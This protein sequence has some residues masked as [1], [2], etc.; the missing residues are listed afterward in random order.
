MEPLSLQMSTSTSRLNKNVRYRE[1]QK[2]D[3]QDRGK[4]VP[5]FKRRIRPHPE[6]EG[7]NLKRDEIESVLQEAFPIAIGSKKSVDNI[8]FYPVYMV[9]DEKKQRFVQIGL[10]EF[11]TKKLPNY[12]MRRSKQQLNFQHPHFPRPLYYSF[13]TGSFLLKMHKLIHQVEKTPSNSDKDVADGDSESGSES[14]SESDS[15]S[16]IESENKGEN[17]GESGKERT[18]KKTSRKIDDSVD[19]DVDMK[20]IQAQQKERKGRRLHGIKHKSNDRTHSSKTNQET[21]I[22][23][24]RGGGRKNQT[25][26][27]LPLESS[28]TPTQ[29]KTKR[30][31]DNESSEEHSDNFIPSYRSDIFTAI[32]GVAL[33][34]RSRKE[35]TLEIA[36]DYRREYV[37]RPTNPWVQACFH[38]N[39]YTIVASE[40]GSNCL[41]ATVR[42]AFGQIAQQ[43]TVTKL[44]LKVANEITMTVFSDFRD[45]YD[46]FRQELSVLTTKVKEMEG[47]Y[48]TNQTLFAQTTDLAT[49]RQMVAI[50]KLIAR[51][52]EIL[53]QRRRIASKIFQDLKFMQKLDT[54]EKFKTKMQT[55]DIWGNAWMLS[56]MER[57][58]NVKFVVLNYEA[59]KSKDISQILWCDYELWDENQDN[60]SFLRQRG[61]FDPD[62]YILL[63]K[64]G[65]EYKLVAYKKKQIFVFEELPYDL[66]VLIAEKCLEM[67]GVCCGNASGGG[68]GGGTGKSLFSLIPDFI[69]FQN[70]AMIKNVST[71]NKAQIQQRDKEELS[72][73]SIRNLFDDNI[74]LQIHAHATDDVLPG[75]GAGEKMSYQTMLSFANLHSVKQWRQK[76][77]DEWLDL[78]QPFLADGHYW[79]SVFHFCQASKFKT[80]NP[81]YYLLFTAESATP[82]SKQIDLA[83][84]AGSASGEFK[85]RRIRPVDI[86]IDKRACSVFLDKMLPMAYEAKF[87]QNEEM[88]FLL[89]ETKNAKIMKFRKGKSPVM[90]DALMLTREKLREKKTLKSDQVKKSSAHIDKEKMESSMTISHDE[91]KI[92][93]SLQKEKEAK[94]ELVRKLLHL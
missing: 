31:K 14:D 15:E 58:L 50:G 81:T 82:L 34:P 59:F 61:S 89:L 79:N 6:E 92:R 1:S 47:K 63:E 49:K 43:T 88:R 57:I 72:E 80:T 73:S 62:F 83:R 21:S 68:G 38:N 37:S 20:K 5:V 87:G 35:E 23:S 40:G 3:K 55:C 48:K 42:D 52:R 10:Y 36:R 28:K 69:R 93:E 27:K 7:V 78:K 9:I 84:A 53:L 41:F 60:V 44:R 70:Q 2:L 77:D 94:R 86:A 12:M 30:S 29:T 8:T 74:V 66:R 13:V 51:N 24:Q 17:K 11:L 85:G 67:G 46:T 45:R 16:N 33:P 75:H 90:C 18:N 64:Y 4:H 56:T 25:K 32:E 26:K 76:L 71:Y 22:A 91:M 39:H 54:L 65:H 19:E